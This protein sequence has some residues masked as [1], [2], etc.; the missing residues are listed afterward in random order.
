LQKAVEEAMKTLSNKT[1][2]VFKMSRFDK[3]SVRDCGTFT[4]FIKSGGIPYYQV[5]ESVERTFKIFS[6]Q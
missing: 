1:V 6:A 4:A 3:K 2:E 5:S